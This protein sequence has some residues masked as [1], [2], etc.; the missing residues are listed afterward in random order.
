MRAREDQAAA[1]NPKEDPKKLNPGES[2]MDYAKRHG[3][4]SSQKPSLKDR[5]KSK[6]GLKKE[7]V[8]HIYEKS[9]SKSQQRF[10]GMVYAAKKGE[11]PASPEVA[12]A[13]AGISKGEAK[14]FAGTKHKGLP[15][16]K[17]EKEVK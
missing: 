10:M 15:E 17:E 7:E 14:K 2:Y 13:A 4:K 5:L 9:V 1:S 8:E 3:Y 6:L 11:K 12:K 16:V